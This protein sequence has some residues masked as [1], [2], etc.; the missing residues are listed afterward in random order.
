MKDMNNN[1]ALKVVTELVDNIKAASTAENRL[2]CF[3]NS[4][5]VALDELS[6]LVRRTGN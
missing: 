2:L 4:I 6:K 1:V 5:S 3:R